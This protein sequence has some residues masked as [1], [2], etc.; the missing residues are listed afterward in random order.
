MRLG[1]GLVVVTRALPGMAPGLYVD[2]A[3]GSALLAGIERGD[4]I[5][6]AASTPVATPAEFDAALAQAGSADTV[7]LLVARGMSMVYLPVARIE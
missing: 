1:L 4:R 6:A 2:S 3:T 7:A 5:V